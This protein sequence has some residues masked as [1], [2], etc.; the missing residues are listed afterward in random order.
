MAAAAL[1]TI[2]DVDGVVVDGVVVVNVDE[3]DEEDDDVDVDEEIVEVELLELLLVV[4][5]TELPLADQVTGLLVA[6]LIYWNA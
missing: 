3:V 1:E 5:A 4:A 2:E 6:L